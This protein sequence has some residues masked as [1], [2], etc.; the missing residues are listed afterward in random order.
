MKKL[1]QLL[2]LKNIKGLGNVKINKT[3]LRLL[4][5]FD[6]LDDLIT[7]IEYN[8]NIA[9]DNLENAKIKAEDLYEKIAND[10]EMT[11]ITLFDDEYPD[12]LLDLGDKKPLI[13][14]VR[15]N[16]DALKMANIAIIGT[17]KPSKPS[18]V[19]E[20]NLTKSIVNSTD[21]V[22]VSG[23]ALGCDKIA[24]KATVE[25]GK[26]TVAILPGDVY[27]IKP[28]SHKRLAEEIIETGGCLVSEYEPGVNVRK[29]NYVERDRIVAAFCDA[30][31]VVECGVKS[32]TM[33]TVNFASEYG[34]PIYAYLPEE[35]SEGS[36]DG[37]EF[38]LE[39]KNGILVE[40]VGEFIGDL[41]TLNVEKQPKLG[42]QTLI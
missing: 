32:G 24:H 33:H 30:T 11:A 3:Y 12:K 41:E 38:I 1:K 17:R 19:F 6:D 29:G 14:Y 18:Q 35:R 36:Y 23:L 20:E 13:L 7:E 9:L 42:Q 16:V 40:D 25:E 34:R 28:A 10:S 5:E 26:T 2:F 39:N 22:I 31:F 15:G 21:R 37:N 8:F 27:K 4:D